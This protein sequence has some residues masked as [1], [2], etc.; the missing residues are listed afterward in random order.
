MDALKVFLDDTVAWNFIERLKFTKWLLSRSIGVSDPRVLI[1][2]PLLS[3]MI[4]PTLREWQA[5]MPEAS[6]PHLWLGLLRCD[7]PRQHIQRALELDPSNQMAR[8][9]L[10]DWILG[11]VEYSQH[12][13][14]EFYIGDPEADLAILARA[15][16][17]TGLVEGQA[18]KQVFLQEITELRENA[19]AWIKAGAA[20]NK[21]LAR[22]RD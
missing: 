2:H 4:V 20:V 3:R 1:P 21:L 15:Q 9:T 7:D 18:R 16:H 19:K 12:H 14:P 6:E 10:I 8:C 11:D 17:L 13:F 22:L 5:S